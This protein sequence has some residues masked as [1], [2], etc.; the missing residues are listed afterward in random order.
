MESTAS[1]QLDLE[2][3]DADSSSC[4]IPGWLNLFIIYILQY[5]SP[6]GS[7]RAHSTFSPLTS[8]PASSS[9]SSTPTPTWSSSQGKET[10]DN[11]D[12]TDGF[13]ND[14][15]VIVPP[16]CIYILIYGGYYGCPTC[17]RR[18]NNVIIPRSH[19]KEILRKSCSISHVRDW[20]N[21]LF[22][23]QMISTCPQIILFCT[24]QVHSVCRDC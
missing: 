10:G 2:Q 11:H 1:S 6:P 18:T 17:E 16:L 4:A 21:F 3:T 20:P 24:N 13:L 22:S 7:C 12:Q 14:T 19:L 9:P 8:P 15:F 5:F 23:L